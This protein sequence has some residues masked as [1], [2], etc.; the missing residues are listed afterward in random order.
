MS[1]MSGTNKAMSYGR[2]KEA[3]PRLAAEVERWLAQAAQTDKAEAPQV[4]APK[5]GHGMPEWDGQIKGRTWRKP[6]PPRPRCKLNPKP[7]PPRSR[8]TTAP[9]TAARAGQDASPS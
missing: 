5:R 3:E 8:T 6:V 2:M 9:A 1:D 7:K 4:G